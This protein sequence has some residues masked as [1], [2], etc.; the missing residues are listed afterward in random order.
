[1]RRAIGVYRGL[2]KNGNL[3]GVEGV[4][5][6]EDVNT[7]R[8]SSPSPVEVQA[9]GELLAAITE[10]NVTFQPESLTVAVSTAP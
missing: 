9:D 1:M 5:V 8:V 4:T 7:F 2:G 10:L 6:W 3:D